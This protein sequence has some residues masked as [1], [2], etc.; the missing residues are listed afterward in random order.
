M[1]VKYDGWV[2]G[3]WVP[4]DLINFD[5]PFCELYNDGDLN[6]FKGCMTD[7]TRGNFPLDCPDGVV[8]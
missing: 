8:R 4:S 7:G 2:N 6:I 3:E 5:F 1:Y